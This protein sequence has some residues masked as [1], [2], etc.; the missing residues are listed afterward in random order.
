[1][2]AGHILCEESCPYYWNLLV[3]AIIILTLNPFP[4]LILKYI[5]CC[6]YL[7]MREEIEH[8]RTYIWALILNQFNS[9]NLKEYIQNDFYKKCIL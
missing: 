9:K 2:P 3:V 1:M 6:T 8:D 5:C 4:E 7:Y